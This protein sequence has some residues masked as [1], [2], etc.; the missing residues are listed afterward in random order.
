[1]VA[2]QISVKSIG[3]AM[4]AAAFIVA[5]FAAPAVAAS[6]HP[7]FSFHSD[8]SQRFDGEKDFCQG[9][10]RGQGRCDMDNGGGRDG[11]QKRHGNHG[12]H[13]P[14]SSA[15]GLQFNSGDY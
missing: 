9:Q 8:N 6:N 3:R 4:G 13:Q 5:M 7:S 2:G 10:Q 12:P 1:M 15:F 14:A 11:S